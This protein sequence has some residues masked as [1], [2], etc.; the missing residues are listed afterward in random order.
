M[1]EKL[2]L[3]LN[4]RTYMECIRE[5]NTE[6]NFRNKKERKVGDRIVRRFVLPHKLNS[7]VLVRKQTIPRHSIVTC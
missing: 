1:D 6:E 5:H 2:G 4:V 3:L 7:V